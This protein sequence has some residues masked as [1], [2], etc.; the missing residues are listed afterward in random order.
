MEINKKL[1]TEIRSHR[2]LFSIANISYLF[3]H[4]HKTENYVKKYR[5][6]KILDISYLNLTFIVNIIGLFMRT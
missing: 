3:T 4:N 2:N 1:T 6:Q 5:I